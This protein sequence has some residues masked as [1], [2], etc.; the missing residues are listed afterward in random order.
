M[1]INQNGTKKQEI[2]TN[3]PYVFNKGY[4]ATA[5]I[6]AG[7]AG[8]GGAG[9]HWQEGGNLGITSDYY[10]AGGAGGGGAVEYLKVEISSGTAFSV[11]LGTG[12]SYGTG[13]IL[14]FGIWGVDKSEYGGNGN[15]G[16]KTK[17][18]LN[19]NEILTAVGGKGGKG[20][21]PNRVG[22]GGGGGISSHGSSANGKNGGVGTRAGSGINSFFQ[23][24][25]NVV[26]SGGS[27]DNFTA[28]NGGYG[29]S[30]NKTPESGGRGDDGSV[31]IIF[32]WYE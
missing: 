13:A 15:D 24:R 14:N 31:K 22:M 17:V 6:Y 20:G 1:V 25:N 11:T 32:T 9:G 2:I 29:G 30:A 16:G 27:K 3:F 21:G 4:S 5:E 12:G 10:S 19:G 8:G 23:G 18:F 7:G 26:G 28:G